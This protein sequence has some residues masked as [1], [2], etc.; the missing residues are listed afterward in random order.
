MRTHEAHQTAEDIRKRVDLLDRAMTIITRKLANV[1]VTGR[2]RAVYLSWD[3]AEEIK[4]ALRAAGAIPDN[5][6]PPNGNFL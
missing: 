1:F 2:G 3:D 6:N 4:A 5:M